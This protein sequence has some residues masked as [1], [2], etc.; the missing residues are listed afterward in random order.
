MDLNNILSS[1]SWLSL[2]RLKLLGHGGRSLLRNADFGRLRLKNCRIF[3][4]NKGLCYYYVKKQWTEEKIQ[5]TQHRRKNHYNSSTSSKT[6]GFTPQKKPYQNVLQLVPMHKQT[7]T[8]IEVEKINITDPDHVETDD[9]LA[10]TWRK[11]VHSTL[12]GAVLFD[13][14]LIHRRVRHCGSAFTIRLVH[15]MMFVL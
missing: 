13:I 11:L 15:H 8:N 14:E 1:L 12:Y 10:W 6:K 3:F 2:Y 4:G 5:K 9:T 7:V